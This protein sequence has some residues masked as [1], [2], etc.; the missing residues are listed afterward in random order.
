MIHSGYAK[1]IADR[2]E[3]FEKGVRVAG[4]ACNGT[5]RFEQL[6]TLK[7]QLI[8]P[9]PWLSFEGVRCLFL[10]A[11]GFEAFRTVDR[12]SFSLHDDLSGSGALPQTVA[13]PVRLFV[14]THDY[15]FGGGSIR[16]SVDGND[17]VSASSPGFSG[18]LRFS[19]AACTARSDFDVKR[20]QL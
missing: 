17:E 18:L 13:E 1:T 19:S 4:G 20:I 11:L 7:I 3:L 14:S 8:A 15:L 12:D 16:L 10:M 6:A 5:W 2:V 9:G